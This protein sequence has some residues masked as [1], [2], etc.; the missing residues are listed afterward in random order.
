MSLTWVPWNSAA[1]LY[2]S[3]D[4]EV[5]C[6]FRLQ[7]WDVCLLLF[8]FFFREKKRKGMAR[9]KERK[10]RRLKSSLT[11]KVIIIAG[12]RKYTSSQVTV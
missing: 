5:C 9:R 11:E 8:S 12:E 1:N 10:T 4:P 2:E 3:L 6:G 7:Q